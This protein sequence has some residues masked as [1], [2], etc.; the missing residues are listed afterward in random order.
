MARISTYSLDTNVDPADKLLG[1]SSEG[2]TKN[3]QVSDIAHF[4]GSTNATGI[5]GSVPFKYTTAG[6]MASGTMQLLN[7]STNKPFP[8]TDNVRLVVSKYQNGLAGQLVLAVLNTYV[9]KDIVIS[10][11]QDPSVF[12]VYRVKTVTQIGSTDYYEILM[13]HLQSNNNSDGL[14][15]IS[16]VYYILTPY[17]GAQDK[18]FSLSFSTNDLVSDSGQ[19]YLL[20]NHNL[21]K[22]P[23]ITVKISTGSIVQVPIVH[24]TNNQSK[25]FFKGLNSGVIHAN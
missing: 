15:F 5:A 25:V 6:V 19:Y 14:G 12:A 10:Q 2:G 20:V 22:F 3:F 8:E 13:T 18:D 7:Q 11:V 21:G 4:L 9:T 1:T 24:I 17:S 23:N 16:E